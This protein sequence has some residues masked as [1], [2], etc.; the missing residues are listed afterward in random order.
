MLSE[1]KYGTRDL[2]FSIWARL[3]SLARYVGVEC[4][5]TASMVDVD[6]VLWISTDTESKAPLCLLEVARD[7]GQPYKPTTA[8][9]ALARRASVP[10]YLAFYTVA[11]YR[12]PCD[13]RA[14]DITQFRIRRLHPRPEF[15]YR[16][17][18]PAEFA[19]AILQIRAWSA[20][21][22]DAQMLDAANDPHYHDAPPIPMV[23]GRSNQR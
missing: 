8:I 23:L 6:S 2:T 4:A 14:A 3:R 10:A 22:L 20:R 5:Q 7:V 11:P 12:N 21:R 18:Q 1:E 15:G 13:A 19:E 16:T 9:T 17:L